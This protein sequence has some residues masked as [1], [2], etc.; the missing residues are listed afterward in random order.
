MPPAL[1]TALKDAGFYEGIDAAALQDPNYLPLFN[2]NAA[3][4]KGKEVK[5]DL[6]LS[7]P[8]KARRFL[9]FLGES[10]GGT[11]AFFDRRQKRVRPQGRGTCHAALR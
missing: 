8:E 3:K 4:G 7:W 9:V 11:A 5:Y 10:P 6:A 1:R 2:S